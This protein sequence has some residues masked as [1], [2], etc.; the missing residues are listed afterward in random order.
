MYKRQSRHCL[1]DDAV[2]TWYKHQRSDGVP[3][4]GVGLQALAERFAQKL[5]ETDFKVSTCFKFQQ[6]HSILNRKISGESLST[7]SSGVEPFR[8]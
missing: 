6:R 5:G 7:A 1:L 3:V 4:K 2:Y 8:H